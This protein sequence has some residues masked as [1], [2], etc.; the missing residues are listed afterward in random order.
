MKKLHHCAF[1]LHPLTHSPLSHLIFQCNAIAAALQ[2]QV[3]F[4]NANADPFGLLL[5]GTIDVLT[6]PRTHTM[7]RT[8]LEA[9]SGTGFAFSAP[10]LYTGLQAAGDPFFVTNCAD[11]DFRH[12]DDCA[13]L[14]VCV[15]RDSTHQVILSNLM[16]VRK[17]VPVDSVDALRTELANGSCNVIVHEGHNLAET[18]VRAEGYTSK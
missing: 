8:L 18:L 6:V 4:V 5:N 15:Q 14:R 12:L 1:H 17:I 9:K 7:E 10:Y 16:S 11:Q 13:D 2:I 3:E